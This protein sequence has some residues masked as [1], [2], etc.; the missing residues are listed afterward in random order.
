MTQ[1][2]LDTARTMADYYMEILADNLTPSKREEAVWRHSYYAA[3]A[4]DLAW[5]ERPALAGSA[6][7]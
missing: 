6:V 4:R 7:A 3:K 5:I 1:T 2:E